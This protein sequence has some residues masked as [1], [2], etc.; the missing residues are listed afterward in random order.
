MANIGLAA[1]AVELTRREFGQ[2]DG[3]IINHGVLAPVT[4]VVDSNPV[5]WKHNFDVNFFSAVAFVSNFQCWLKDNRLMIARLRQRFQNFVSAM[6]ASYSHH[7]ALQHTHTV[8]GELTEHQ[9]LHSII[10]V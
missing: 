5:N 7:L 3:L 9:K 4:R 8:R 1:E 2:I 10:S 6:V